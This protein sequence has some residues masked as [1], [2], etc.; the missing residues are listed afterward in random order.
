MNK[1]TNQPSKNRLVCK[2]LSAEL[3]RVKEQT[4]EMWEIVWN[5]KL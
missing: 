4:C 3:P 1:S 2:S 5:L